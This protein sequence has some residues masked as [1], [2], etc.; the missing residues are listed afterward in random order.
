MNKKA[1]ACFRELWNAWY[2]RKKKSNKA[3]F[4]IIKHSIMPAGT[5]NHTQ[6]HVSGQW[7]RNYQL[8][9]D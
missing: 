8:W 2:G 4:N 1:K 5:K 9:T 6:T 7:S 3:L